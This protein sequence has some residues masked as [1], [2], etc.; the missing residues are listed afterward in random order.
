MNFI[1]RQ[2]RFFKWLLA[3]P[4][5]IESKIYKSRPV[6]HKHKPLSNLCKVFFDNKAIEFI[7]F[8]PS[9][10]HDPAVRSSLPSNINNFDVRTV[11]FSLEKSIHNRIFNFNT[12]VS[13][14]DADRGLQENVIL[15]CD[16]DGSEFIDQHHKHLLT[17]TRN[18]GSYSTKC[19]NIEKTK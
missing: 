18:S 4:D 6:I 19:L 8:L 3:A 2:D 1:C 11:V 14:L 17:D 7:N 5:E 9:I 16:Y 13:N 12:F 10:L 15:P